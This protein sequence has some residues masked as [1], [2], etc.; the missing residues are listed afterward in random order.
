VLDPALQPV[1]IGVPGE[2]LIGGP[3]LARGYLNR[4]ELTDEKF[5]PN[6]FKS[7]PQERLY[8]SGDLVRYLPDGNIE[9]MGRVDDQVKIRGFRVELG[10]IEAAISQHPQVRENVVIAWEDENS[11]KR[12]VA[13]LIL[14]QESESTIS[15]IRSYLKQ[16]LPDYMI[17]ANFVPLNH[18]PMTPN[19]KVDRKSLPAPDLTRS[20]QDNQFT[21][22]RN[23]IEQTLTQI[24][25]DLLK[26][27]KIGIDDNFFELGGDSILS[28]QIIAKANQAGVKLTPIQI[29]EHQTIAELAM[30]AGSSQTIQAEQGEV[31]GP[32][33]L[34][35]YQQWFFEQDLADPHHWN[36]APLLEVKQSLDPDLV[37]KTVQQLTIHHDALRLRFVRQSDNTWQQTNAGVAQSKAVLSTQIDLTGLSAS[38]QDSIM[39]SAFADLQGELNLENGPLIKVA[40]ILLGPERPDRLLFIVHHMVVDGISLRILLEDFNQIYEQLSNNQT[41]IL[42]AKTT[43]YQQWTTSLTKY[44]RSEAA[45]QEQDYWIEQLEKQVPRLPRD[46]QTG[47]NIEGSTQSVWVSLSVEDT[48]ALLKEVPAAYNTQIN[49]VL[50]TALVQS[51]ANWTDSQTLVLALEGHG[52]ENIIEDVDLSRT[53]G[54]FTSLFPV[55]LDLDDVYDLGGS[56]KSVKEQLYAIPNRGIGYGLL[57]YLNQDSEVSSKLQA[58]PQAEISFNYL[59]QFDQTMPASNS[60]SLV[61]NASGPVRSPRGMRRYLIDILGIM[62]NGQLYFNWIYSENLHQR[63]T[64][65][66]LAWDFIDALNA[67]ITHCK[68]EDAGGY[69]PSDFPEA[70][71]SQNELDKFLANFNK[72]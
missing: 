42:P 66:D 47:I 40:L 10:E 4:P 69:T 16:N 35:P 68:S 15:E 26:V 19:G 32:V 43:S 28:I 61:Q 25:S 27:E 7:D 37:E 63:S 64:I 33:N 13:Y 51:F 41:P 54:C 72:G 21:A 67:L 14:N 34:A 45:L 38:E 49:D 65:E 12:L 58:L 70:K 23:Q 60:F 36:M 5:I 62:S 24:W 30:V 1:P 52:R 2:L 55:L 11:R 46:N 44:A 53:V 50:L 56:L 29:F 20:E 3:G 18:L 48:E 59:G 31:T 9:F 57:Y 71:L 6:P 22:P 39:K 17:P 8:K